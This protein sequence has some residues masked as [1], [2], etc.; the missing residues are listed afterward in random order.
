M[1]HPCGNR[2]RTS[3]TGRADLQLLELIGR[4]GGLLVGGR[5]TDW[6]HAMQRLH[7]E[8]GGREVIQRTVPTTLS[9]ITLRIIPASPMRPPPREVET[10]SA[11]ARPTTPSTAAPAASATA[12]EKERRSW[13]EAVSASSLA[14]DE[15]R[16][17]NGL[18][19]LPRGLAATPTDGKG[20]LHRP[21]VDVPL[22]V[23]PVRVDVVAVAAVEPEA[24]P[25]DSYRQLSRVFQM[26]GRRAPAWRPGPR[27]SERGTPGPL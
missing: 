1:T 21:A 18:L 15:R 19:V 2:H 4:G 5:P 20:A 14:C 16:T 13:R 8:T 9:V 22:R 12:A 11:R 26:I 17:V 7:D 23:R 6:R 27:G 10:V 25:R 3:L 24:S